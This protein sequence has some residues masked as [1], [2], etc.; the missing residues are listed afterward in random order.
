[1]FIASVIRVFFIIKNKVHWDP[2]KTWNLTTVVE[3][4]DGTTFNRPFKR[5]EY[6]GQETKEGTV[7][8]I[9]FVRTELKSKREL[10]YEKLCEKWR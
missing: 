5:F 2:F 10:E 8:G 4:K 9:Y 1:M 7:T 6:V 3:R